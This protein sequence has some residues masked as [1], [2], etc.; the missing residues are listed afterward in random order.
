MSAMTGIVAGVAVIV[1]TV[2]AARFLEK[3]TR[4]ARRAFAEAMRQSES[5]ERAGKSPLIIDLEKDP[6]SGAYRQTETS[7]APD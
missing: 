4:S 7:V 1:G 2:A 6:V 3:R 5:E